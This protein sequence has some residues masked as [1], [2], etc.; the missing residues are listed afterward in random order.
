MPHRLV[1]ALP[2]EHRIGTLRNM[3]FPR[4][5]T[6]NAI[7]VCTHVVFGVTSGS[8]KLT[9]TSGPLVKLVKTHVLIY[10]SYN[11]FDS[12]PCSGEHEIS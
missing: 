2:Y 11:V 9:V 7:V 5:G 6:L 8:F 1:S 4:Q 3:Q 10:V 12:T